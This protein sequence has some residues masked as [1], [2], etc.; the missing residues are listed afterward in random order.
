MKR[1]IKCAAAIGAAAFALSVISSLPAAADHR[2]DCDRGRRDVRIIE[3]RDCL[4]R[5]YWGDP[6]VRIY[7]PCPPVRPILDVNIRL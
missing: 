4:V 3:R 5:P 1:A 2:G 6:H 7:R